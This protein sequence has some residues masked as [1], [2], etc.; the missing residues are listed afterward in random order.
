MEQRTVKCLTT[1]K[2]YGFI[3]AVKL[4]RCICAFL[5]YSSRPA[6]AALQEGQ[7]VQFEVTKGQRAGRLRI[8]PASS[9][10]R[11]ARYPKGFRASFILYCT[12]QNQEQN[13][14]GQ[15]AKFESAFFN[16]RSRR[17]AQLA[18]ALLVST[19]ALLSSSIAAFAAILIFRFFHKSFSRRLKHCTG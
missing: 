15:P 17:G 18:L 4:V 10:N 7:A 5:R 3:K 8:V 13:R 19:L 16:S 11:A 12:A 9:D 6:F 2:G 14:T 1:T